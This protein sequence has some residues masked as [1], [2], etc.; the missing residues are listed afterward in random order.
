MEQGVQFIMR[1]VNGIMAGLV[2]VW[3]C[4]KWLSYLPV[5]SVRV[6]RNRESSLWL[7][8]RDVVSMRVLVW[9][10]GEECDGMPVSVVEPLC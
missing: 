7:V 1:N 3:D 5:R 2:D 9:C 6:V 8:V 4:R 10:L